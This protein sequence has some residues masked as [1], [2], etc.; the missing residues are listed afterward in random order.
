[1]KKIYIRAGMSPLD[2]FSPEQVLVNNYIGD[3]VGNLLYAYSIFR[4]LML[5][6][7][8]ITPNYYKVNP[9]DAEKIN[10]EYDCFIIPLADAFR[11]D[12]VNEMRNLTALIKRLT[13]PCVVVGVGLKADFGTDLK[14]DF[15]FDEDVKNF[16]KAVLEKSA[17]IGV[18]GEITSAYLTKLG[19]VEGKDHT[20]IGCPS[21]YTYGKNLTVRDTKLTKDSMVCVNNNILCP[22]NVQHFLENSMKQIENHYFLP[23]RIQEFR[24]TYIGAPYFHNQKRD[25]YPCDMNARLYKE[26]KVRFFVNMPAWLDFLSK[27]ELSFGGR[28]HGNIAGV[29]AGTPSLLIPHDARMKE[30]TEY[31]NLPHIWA[32]DINEQSDIFELFAKTDFKQ[33]LN[34]HEQRFEHYIDFLDKNGLDHIYKNGQHPVETPLDRKLKEL[35]LYPAIET[36]NGCQKEE[37]FDRMKKYYTLEDARKDKLTKEVKKLRKEKRELNEKCSQKQKK[38]EELQK[39]TD[40]LTKENQTLK[41]HEG[42]SYKIKRKVKQ[43]LSSTKES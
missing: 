16:V 36:I 7:T 34:G 9:N 22:N 26:N 33:V 12:F 35:E 25:C 14:E 10:E 39:N 15:P 37:L 30:L 32:K 40:K 38:I 43:H 24:L 17:M 8:I 6:D 13:I 11:K 31:H 2:N 21:M 42:I 19:F 41:Q 28:L 1:M 5:E 18:R 3:N 23:Q 4:T 27:A 29:V 20:V